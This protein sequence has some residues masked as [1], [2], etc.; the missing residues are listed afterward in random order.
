[1]SLKSP[2]VLFYVRVASE[3]IPKYRMSHRVH[4]CKSPFQAQQ[5]KRKPVKCA[6][7]IGNNIK[8]VW[9]E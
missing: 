3:N 6:K 4:L 5:T 7:G 2:E 9:K 1:M 8:D